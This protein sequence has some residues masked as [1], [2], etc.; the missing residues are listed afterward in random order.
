MTNRLN[1][2]RVPAAVPFTPAQARAAGCSKAAIRHALR[3]GTWVALRRGAYVEASHLAAVAESAER[4]H[5]LEVAALLLVIDLDAVASATSAARIFGMDL[6]GRD[7]HR[8][9]SC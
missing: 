7:L 8:N 3:N 9:L 6:L 1:A 2:L 5:A 4:R